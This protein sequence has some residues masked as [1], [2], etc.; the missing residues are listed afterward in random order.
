[1]P[2]PVPKKMPEKRKKVPFFQLATVTPKAASTSG[3]ISQARA[4]VKNAAA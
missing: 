2:S 3:R 1:M 4:A